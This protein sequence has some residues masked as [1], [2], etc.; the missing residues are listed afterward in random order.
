M[1][2]PDCAD[3]GHVEDI[4]QTYI[5]IDSIT[6]PG[7]HEADLNSGYPAVTADANIISTADLE[8]IEKS[9][10]KSSPY[11]TPECLDINNTY[12][13]NELEAGAT[14]SGKWTPADKDPLQIYIDTG[15]FEKK[16]GADSGETKEGFRRG[17]PK[18]TCVSIQECYETVNKQNT[19][20]C[21]VIVLIVCIALSIGMVFVFRKV[22]KDRGSVTTQLQAANR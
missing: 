15:E 12:C 11:R 8:N 2:P 16:T 7:K 3:D 9:I 19:A 4:E 18:K 10:A 22:R 20:S 6:S 14:D 17:K 5:P 1:A 21:I 13:T